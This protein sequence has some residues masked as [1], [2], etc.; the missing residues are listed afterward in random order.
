MAL[1]I[2][3]GYGVAKMRWRS[4]GDGE[5]MISTIGFQ[6]DGSPDVNDL[7]QAIGTHWLECWPMTSMS[8]TYSFVGVDVAYGPEGSA[9]VG[10]WNTNAAGGIAVAT[11]PSNCALLIS[12]LTGLGGK[13]NKGRMYLPAAYLSEGEV[14]QNGFLSAA[15]LAQTQGFC[16]NFFN[17]NLGATPIVGLIGWV[18]LHSGDAQTPSNMPTPIT[19][20][21]PQTQIATQRQRMRR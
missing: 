17:V 11:C 2:P 8:S 1:V 5:E 12:K 4:Q 18:L 9:E 6:G 20:L 3:E 19:A 13:A 21:Q 16:S 10:E 14:D 15:A 7:A